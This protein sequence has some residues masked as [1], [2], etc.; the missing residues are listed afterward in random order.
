MTAAALVEVSA[1]GDRAEAAWFSEV[2]DPSMTFESIADSGKG[3]FKNKIHRVLFIDPFK[4][5]VLLAVGRGLSTA[6]IDY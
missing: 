6:G 3:R 4:K 1:Y 2:N 5:R